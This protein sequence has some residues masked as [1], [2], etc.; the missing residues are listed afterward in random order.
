MKILIVSF[1]NNIYLSLFLVTHVFVA[2]GL[3]LVVVRGLLIVVAPL[4]AQALS[5]RAQ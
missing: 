2:P 3:S 1:L 4:V 5:A